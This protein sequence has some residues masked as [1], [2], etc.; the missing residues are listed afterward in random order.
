[1][2]IRKMDW[3]IGADSSHGC[4]GNIIVTAQANDS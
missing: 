3:E 1:M 4:M 2:T